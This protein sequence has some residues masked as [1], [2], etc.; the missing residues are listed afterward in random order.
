[1]LSTHTELSELW[2]KTLIKVWCQFGRTI[3]FS[4]QKISWSGKSSR[5]ME[6]KYCQNND[7]CFDGV[8]IL[9][10]TSFPTV[11]ISNTRSNWKVAYVLANIPSV[12]L[13]HK[14][15]FTAPTKGYYF[16]SNQICYVSC[17]RAHG[18]SLDGLWGKS[19]CTYHKVAQCSSSLSGFVFF[20]GYVMMYLVA[21]NIRHMYVLVVKDNKLMSE[22]VMHKWWFSHHVSKSGYFDS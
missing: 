21:A 2:L 12:T 3:P 10:F 17:Q 1:M 13:R 6:M 16:Q 20:I 7:F 4:T 8:S 22:W 18:S 11:F 15:I 9:H 19:V 5:N 14:T